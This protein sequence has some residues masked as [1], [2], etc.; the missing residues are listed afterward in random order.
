MAGLACARSLGA[1]E[2]VQVFGESLLADLVEFQIEDGIGEALP[3]LAD[4]AECAAGAHA[5]HHPINRLSPCCA[6]GRR[7]TGP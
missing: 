4:L 1:A 5:Q 7:R 2:I 6:G 3:G